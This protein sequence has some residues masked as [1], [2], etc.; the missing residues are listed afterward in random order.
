[1]NALVPKPPLCDQE[2]IFASLLARVPGYI[3]EWIP[4][5]SMAGQAVLRV[6]A[7]YLD[8]L[9]NGLQQLPERSKLAFLDMLGIGLLPAQGA[10]A[11]LVFSLV[12]N[13]PIDVTLPARSEV[14]AQLAPQVDESLSAGKTA[15]ASAS[16]VIFSTEQAITLSRAKLKTLY[17][18]NPGNDEFVD[19][20]N[21]LVQGF[22]FFGDMQRCLHAIYL[23]HDVLFALA[24]SIS[25]IVSVTLQSGAAQILRTEWEYLTDQG[26]LPLEMANEDDTTDGWRKDGQMVVRRE[27]GPNAKQETFA[28]RTS[29][30]IRGRL[31]EPLFPEGTNGKRTAPVVDDLRV[32]VA[33]RKEGIAPDAAFADVV[34]LDTSKDFF[35]FGEQPTQHPTF[36]LAS[37]E[38]FQ[39]KGAQIRLDLTLSQV[40]NPVS[41]QLKWEY[42]D[43]NSWARLERVDPETY[44]FTTSG[45]LSFLCP[46]DWT[47][48]TVN[49]TKSYWLRVRVAVGDFG[50]PL[51]LNRLPTHKIISVSDDGLVLTVDTNQGYAGGESVELKKEVTHPVVV[52]KRDGLDKIVLTS[53]LPDDKR[54]FSGGT[55]GDLSSTQSDPPKLLPAT[56]QP[57]VISSLH[58]GYI[59]TTDPTMLDHC[60][61]E[62][63]FVFAD[64]TEACRWSDR[65]FMPFHPVADQR[66]TV[67]IGFDQPLPPGL[68]SL[69]L[70]VPQVV[71]GDLPETSG[72]PFI[73]EYRS[74]R[75]WTELSVLDAT[76]GFRRSGM[77]QFIGSPDAIRAPGLGG[78]CIWL[79]AQ[80]KPG[81]RMTPIPVAGIWLNAVWAEQSVAIEQEPLGITDGNP[82]QTFIVQHPPIH[83]GET[84]EIQEWTGQ[85]KRWRFDL[86]GVPESDLRFERN[87]ATQEVTAVW[88]RWKEQPHF[89]G[90]TT[91]DRF[92]VV[93]RSR[94]IARLGDG[95][96]GMTPPSGRLVRIS[97]RSGEAVNG[98]IRATVPAGTITELRMAVPYVAS[99]INPVA[100]TGG[101][102]IE[103]LDAVKVRGPQQIR[104][105]GRGIS[106]EDLEWLA[107][108]ATP[109]VARVRCLALT[110]PAG[111]A[112]RGWVTIIVVPFSPEAEPQPSAET[113]RR[114]R[115]Y[116]A[117]RVPVALSRGI[118]VTGP[119]YTRVG[120]RAE[121]VPVQPD[122]AA[123]VEVRVR[124]NLQRYLHPL[125]GG[126]NHQGWQF[127]QAVRLSQIARVI[128]AIEGVDY[129]AQ[130]ILVN[131]GHLFEDQI[132][133]NPDGLVASGNHELTLTVGVR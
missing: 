34:P 61:T 69:Y 47:E 125:T 44:Q 133:I 65:T 49:G 57:P 79:R 109:E 60:L 35:P 123:A 14:A 21:R 50:F 112:Q 86:A 106:V 45:S 84:L 115:D 28:N 42:W 29:Y 25:V 91:V 129:A 126:Q 22:G 90:A 9:Q 52:A 81:A 99:A 128:E 31:T 96:H 12:E 58:L 87:A 127:G 24:G 2:H 74:A 104:H 54:N 51:R 67:H 130:L 3:P 111:H 68:I 117:M 85:G 92:Y 98:V 13:S 78:E 120:I 95:E 75:G 105:G 37:K 15:T 121:I 89:Y 122:Q 11:P 64:E 40:G 7:R 114:V 16:A 46:R 72:S 8:L 103:S 66:P 10:R 113:K 73:W 38:V 63:D 70:D 41:M 33:I 110:G 97:Y 118:R 107:R 116:L 56:L 108:E 36:Y 119:Q 19:H 132:P 53:A 82:D 26:W 93:D 4:G 17:S 80:L 71:V 27:C 94:G 76:Q 77:V 59:Y 101:A 124:E 32:R 88:V 83:N 5:S 102:A 39:R 23:G 55:I 20:S 48:T 100:A 18:I 1:M 62:N 30:W 6:F 131:D 43:G